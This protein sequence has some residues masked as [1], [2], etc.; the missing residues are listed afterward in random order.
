MSSSKNKRSKK[1]FVNFPI[2]N[3][4]GNERLNTISQ[5]NK[6]SLYQKIH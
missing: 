5:K 1:T 6:N 2:S 4:G 3:F